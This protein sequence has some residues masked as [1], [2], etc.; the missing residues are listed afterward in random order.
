MLR[1]RRIKNQKLRHIAGH[2]CF[3]A[4][5]TLGKLLCDMIEK[6]LHVRLFFLRNWDD[7][8]FAREK[9]SKF[10]TREQGCQT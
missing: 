6:P 7:R 4:R 3:I 10:F 8:R 2:G 5:L 1:L 9:L